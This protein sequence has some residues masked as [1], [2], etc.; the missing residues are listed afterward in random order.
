[1]NQILSLSA[2]LTL[3][4]AFGQNCLENPVI[5]SQSEEKDS[6]L[7][8]DM[9]I[10]FHPKIGEIENSKANLE[11]RMYD[12]GRRPNSKQ[13]MFQLKSV[14]GEFEIN[15]FEYTEIFEERFTNSTSKITREEILTCKIPVEDFVDSLN[16]LHFFDLP[17]MHKDSF[18]KTDT[19]INNG[20]TRIRKTTPLI[21]DGGKYTV[22]FKIDEVH[23][24]YFYENPNAYLKLFPED[25]NLQ[26]MTRI[27]SLFYKYLN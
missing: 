12:E 4:N 20:E 15:K 26:N 24:S 7:T 5:Y 22:Q 1:M 17:S 9:M 8:H 3:F 13:I 11:L 19:T 21:F 2:F 25:R 16:L 14:N 23:R 10:D 6:A 27:I 18:I